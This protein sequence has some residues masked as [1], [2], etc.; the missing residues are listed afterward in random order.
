MTTRIFSLLLIV[1]LFLTICAPVSNAQS[2]SP[3]PAAVATPQ[4]SNAVTIGQQGQTEQ[5]VSGPKIFLPFALLSRQYA[6]TMTQ[7]LSDNAQQMTLAFD[8]LAFLTGTLGSDS[9]FPP[10]KVADF[11]GF[12]FLRDNDPSE[13][14]HNTDFLT[15]ASLNMLVTLSSDQK[16]QLIALAKSQVASINEYGYKRFVLMTAFRRLLTG[17]LPTGTT[18]LNL[19]AVKAFSA[20]LYHLD[21]VISYERAQVMG[22]I[23]YNLNATQKAYLN[24]MV[25]KGMT[26]WPNVDEPSEL[27][28]LTQDE[29]VAVM[30]YAGDL[31]SWY[32][33]SV[34]AD[35][36]F[37]PERQGTYF[38]SFYMK[39]APAVGNPGYSI[40]TNITAD[41]G[42]AFIEALT[43]TQAPLITGLVAAQKPALYEI[44][45]RREDV[46]YL[47]R[48]FKTGGT[49][50]KATVLSLMDRYGELDGEIVYRYAT[51]FV[52]VSKTLT[53]DQKA[54]LLK[55]RTDLL[56]ELT[57]PTGAYLY[58]QPIALPVV[59][60]TDFLFK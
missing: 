45:A 51:A 4:P 31:F 9:F 6:F 22:A 36:Y 24:A 15:R 23:L 38:G 16:A 11:W 13:M 14:G 10:G 57:Y 8:G 47:L 1:F 21:G 12:Q 56:K 5:V 42:K 28:G 29:K 54:Q 52:E 25:G 17:D 46:S 44:V 30:T 41:L 53:A 7:T 20:E 43:P 2:I 49:P 27:R 59:P 19:D 35:V 34:E 48:Q 58:A 18:A 3:V 60:S 50:N 40:G 39:D 33:G 55:L 26:S 37:C 32:A